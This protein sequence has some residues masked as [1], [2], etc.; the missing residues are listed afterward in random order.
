MSTDEIALGSGKAAEI[1]ED[2]LRSAFASDAADW[3][4]RELFGQSALAHH[5]AC[6]CFDNHV[7]RL[8]KWVLCLG[9]TCMA[10]G[11]IAAAI[12]IALAHMRCPL[13]VAAIGTYGFVALGLLMFMPTL[14]QPFYQAKPF[15]ILARFLLG[16]AVICMWYGAIFLLPLTASGVFLRLLFILVFLVV[17]R[18]TQWQ[19]ALFAKDPCRACEGCVYPF[20]ADN[21]SRL[22]SLIEE[23]EKRAGQEDKA[24]VSFA[25]ALIGTASDTVN[26]EVIDLRKSVIIAQPQRQLMCTHWPLM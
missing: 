12:S 23:L 18:A 24:F 16:V 21:R 25:R 19:R 7:L 11:M 9:C 4:M 20:C 26:V 2:S 17:F 15:K 10:C 1:S 5:P 3:F 6:R 13:L 22:F 8:G 14:A